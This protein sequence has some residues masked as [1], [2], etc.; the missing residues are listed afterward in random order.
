MAACWLWLAGCVLFLAIRFS[1]PAPIDSDILSMLPGAGGGVERAGIDLAS[2]AAAGRVAVLVSAKDDAIANAAASDLTQRLS[3]DGLFLSDTADTSVTARWMF[4]NRNQ[5]LCQGESQAFGAAEAQKIE[6]RATADVF[7]LTGAVTGDLL[8]QDPFLLTIRLSEC[9]PP[10]GVTLTKPNQRLVSGRISASAYRLDAQDQ[11]A[12]TLNAWKALWAPKD[13][14]AARAGAV[15]HAYAA[16]NQAK[17]DFSWIGA[18]GFIG[19]AGLILL[20]F[21][22]AS[23]VVQG[24]LIVPIAIAPGLAVALMVFHTVHILVF[25]F[26][27]TLIG[28]VS[29][30]AI[31][32]MA[33]GPASNWASLHDRLAM[34]FRPLTVSMSTIT[35]GWGALGVFGVPLFQEVAVLASVGIITAWAFAL[36]V[37][38]PMDRR[39][40]A[41]GAAEARISWWRKLEDAREAIRLPAWFVW[42]VTALLAA[43]SIFGATRLTFLDDVRLFQPRQAELIAEE[44]QVKAAGYGGTTVTFLLSDGATLEEAKEN[45]EAALAEAPGASRILASTRFDPSAKRRAEN[46]EALA[47]ELY[48]PLLKTHAETLGLETDIDPAHLASPGN[49]PKPAWLAELSGAAKGRFFLVAPVLE[50]AGWAGPKRE[51][52]RLVDPAITYSEAFKAYRGEAVL[53]LLVAGVCAIGATLLVYRRLSAL[54]ILAPSALAAVMA[55]L[56]PAALGLPL[57]FFSFAAALVLVGD[58]VDYAAFQWEGGL[59]NQRW[60]AVAVALDA[61]TTVLTMGL[62]VFSDTVP[63]RSFGLTVT[64]GIVAALCLSH[65]PKLAA[66]I[67]HKPKGE[68]EP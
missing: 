34:V 40:K 7:S 8:R 20:A 15:F 2:K 64:I 39:P 10:T 36:F 13:V 53:A 44:D 5:L 54:A 47:S 25:V 30:Y 26:A 61:A 1:G 14:T 38:A 31:N 29:D 21:R 9:L 58:G 51:G 52:V 57:T 32:V 50:A 59:K 63:V 65:I 12:A 35:L 68:A 62:L 17:R 48:Q 19:T 42:S 28:I 55:I 18:I 66:R 60:T 6:K 4:E 41:P 11:I 3:K 43:I 27:S 67:G 37:V 22:T 45:E 46:Q 33:T 23:S 24:L 49:A 56:I 16:A